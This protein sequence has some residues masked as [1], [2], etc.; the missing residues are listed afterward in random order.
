M[1]VWRQSWI[2]R[3]G[4]DALGD[5][6]K[7]ATASWILGGFG[8]SAVDGRFGR[9]RTLRR[10]GKRDVAIA[11]LPID[12]ILPDGRSQRGGGVASDFKLCPVLGVRQGGKTC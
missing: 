10:S 7:T 6:A 1:D 12:G 8:S 3:V 11:G 2:N 5:P 4:A 9:D